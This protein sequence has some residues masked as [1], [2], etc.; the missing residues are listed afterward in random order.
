MSEP[1]F[2]GL[3]MRLDELE[4]PTWFMFKFIAPLAGLVQ[5]RNLFEGYPVRF[6]PSRNG[7][8]IGI[9]AELEM[10]SSSDIIAIYKQAAKIEGVILL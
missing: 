3:R 1:S 7:N 2:E 4:Y 5:L 8:Y 6:N 9:T 10:Q